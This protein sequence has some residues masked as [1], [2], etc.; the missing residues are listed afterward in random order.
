M[1]LPDKYF[2][3]ERGPKKWL[4]EN[5]PVTRQHNKNQPP[6]NE[7]DFRTV[8]KFPGNTKAAKI[9]EVANLDRISRTPGLPQSQRASALWLLAEMFDA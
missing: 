1:E 2:V 9:E 4:L 8:A 5:I 6:V 7:M 3:E